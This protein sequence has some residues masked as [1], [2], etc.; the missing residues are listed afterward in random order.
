MKDNSRAFTIRLSRELADQIDARATL[1][2]RT[3]NGEITFLLE[4]AIDQYVSS[5][6]KI[7]ENMQD[8]S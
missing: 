3:R 7:L 1:N 5:D 2:R 4:T 8:R 6:L